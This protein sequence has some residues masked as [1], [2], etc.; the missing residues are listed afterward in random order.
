M[1]NN[2][3]LN[4]ISTR[5]LINMFDLLGDTI[6]WMK[7]NKGRVIHCNQVFVDHLGVKSLDQ[8]IGKTDA[9]FSPP[10]IARQFSLDD[11]KVLAGEHI[12][13][14]V[15]MNVSQSKIGWFS[16]SKRPLKDDRGK[17]IGTYGVTR[18][19]QK[20][21]ES[22]MGISQIREPVEFIKNSYQEKI[23]IEK[24]AQIAHLSVSALERR[25]KKY[26]SKTPKQFIREVRL[27]NARR[28]V[29]ETQLSIS[30][31]AYQSGFAC[32]SYFSRHFKIMFGELPTQYRQTAC[33]AHQ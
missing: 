17:I 14:R 23:T 22:L 27:E 19:V 28:M 2:I 25:F 24:L 16:T 9:D 8:V 6:F 15:E 5:Q 20:M 33:S 7:D 31:I 32:H 30:D 11:E 29:I 3:L 12:T 21:E 13:E 1:N 18:H 4:Q 10:H 26:L